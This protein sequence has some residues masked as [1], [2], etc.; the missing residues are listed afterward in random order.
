MIQNDAIWSKAGGLY[1]SPDVPDF[2]GDP[3][4]REKMT[5]IPDG[6]FPRG[7]II[8]WDAKAGVWVAVGQT[9]G[10]Q[11]S[12]GRDIGLWTSKD[13]RTWSDQQVVIPVAEDESRSPDDW[14]EYYYM[15]GY[16]VGDVWLGMLIL[17][18]T[19]RGN[20]L[21]GTPDDRRTCG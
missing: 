6:T 1:F 3:Q 5:P 18:H 12:H 19:D 2:L 21:M 7:G 14:V 17:F 15:S 13:L 8:G 10:W 16:R 4:W 9:G 11:G 20:P